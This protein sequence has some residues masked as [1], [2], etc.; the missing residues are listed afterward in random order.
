VKAIKAIT[1]NAKDLGE[2]FISKS[3]IDEDRENKN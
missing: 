3:S 1:Y 2:K